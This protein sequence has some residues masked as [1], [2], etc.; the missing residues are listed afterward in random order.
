M[1]VG[2][3]KPSD[4]I[5][6][7]RLRHLKYERKTGRHVDLSNISR[8]HI[9]RGW[10]SSVI[11]GYNT[12]SNMEVTIKVCQSVNRLNG[13]LQHRHC[14]K[15]H[16][17]TTTPGRGGAMVSTNKIRVRLFCIGSRYA[18]SIIIGGYHIHNKYRLPQKNGTEEMSKNIGTNLPTGYLCPST[19]TCPTS[20]KR[21]R[22]QTVLAHVQTLHANKCNPPNICLTQQ[23]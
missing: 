15:T 10:T 5:Y 23:L 13:L 2:I 17:H 7:T 8:H 18:A 9:V 3:H 21:Q 1:S 19:S 16:P 20:M 22:D 6:L 14:H 4:G 12:Q 11:G